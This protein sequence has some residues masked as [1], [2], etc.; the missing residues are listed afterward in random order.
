MVKNNME[1]KREI[2]CPI[3]LEVY[4]EDFEECP[5]CSDITDTSKELKDSWNREELDA[6]LESYRVFVWKNGCT[7]ADLDVWKRQNL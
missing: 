6:I 2:Y 1:Y 5:F 3:C 7:K 4:F